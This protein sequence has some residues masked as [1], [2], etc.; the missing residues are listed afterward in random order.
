VNVGELVE[1]CTPAQ[2]T[3]E[4]EARPMRKLVACAHAFAAHH[5]RLRLSKLGIALQ[6]GR[7]IDARRQLVSP[8]RGGSGATFTVS[9]TLSFVLEI[10]THSSC[11]T[12]SEISPPLV[13]HGHHKK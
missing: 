3:M 6:P 4:C 8:I 10:V 13:S 5:S 12:R 2:I 11:C 9:C 7:L 1:S